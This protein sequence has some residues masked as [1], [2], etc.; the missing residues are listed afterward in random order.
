[1]NRVAPVRLG[2]L[3]TGFVHS[4]AA[5]LRA[6]GQDPLPLLSQYGLDPER[7][8]EPNARLSIPRYMRLGHAA[9]QKANDPALGL[10]MGRCCRPAQLG[11]AGVTA[12]QA[13]TVRDAAR[14][15]IRFEALYAANYRG[16]ASFH[17]DGAGAW[18]RLYSLSPYNGFNRFVV[19]S[20]LSG[21]LQHLSLIA[22][23]P[24]LAERIEIEFEAP[25]YASAYASLSRSAVHFGASE[26]QLRLDQ[27]TLALRNPAYCPG[28]WQA[29][30]GLCE[31]QLEQVTRTY[32]L[33]ERITRLL[34]PLL[35]GGREPSLDE[36]ALRL[37]MPVWTLRRKLSEE[38]TQFRSLLND[39]R[40]DLATTYIRDTDLTFG[41]IAFVLGFASAEAFARA[42]KRWTGETPGAFRRG[43]LRAG[44]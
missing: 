20:V 23:Q 14:T 44:R 38:G 19:D 43:L 11:L 8:A 31:E 1:M 13:P 32:R 35:S 2:D 9:M 7:L 36:V 37:K 12:A 39:T 28:T 42:F 3:S 17:E 16:Q 33:S 24:L 26:N 34:G 30:I 27:A 41:E 25:A 21:W 29:L 40:Q 22:G 5:A 18:L 15:L 6:A 10:A 4:L